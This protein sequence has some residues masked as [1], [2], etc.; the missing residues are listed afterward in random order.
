MFSKGS[1]SSISFATVTPSWVMVGE[2]NLRSSATLRPLGPRVVATALATI[3]TPAFSR[4]RA[5][6]AKTNRLAAIFQNLLQM[7]WK[8][9]TFND[10]KQVAFAQDQKLLA[11]ELDL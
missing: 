4:R 3:S 6:S 1:S 10:C 7:L 2:P 9:L 8:K 11:I 5:S